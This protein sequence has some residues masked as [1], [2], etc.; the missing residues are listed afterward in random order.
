MTS[1]LALRASVCVSNSPGMLFLFSILYFLFIIVIISLLLFISYIYVVS[2]LSV[3]CLIPP[4]IF[5]YIGLQIP[6]SSAY[7][8]DV[9][10]RPFDQREAAR[11]ILAWKGDRTILDLHIFILHPSRLNFALDV[12]LRI[13]NRVLTL[14]AWSFF[15]F[16]HWARDSM[17]R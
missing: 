17:Q 10:P 15:V 6:P 3:E 2:S 8:T 14:S 11:S 12:P 4:I 1:F 16:R 13:R 7:A 5:D 9:G